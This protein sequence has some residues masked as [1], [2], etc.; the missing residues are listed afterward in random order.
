MEKFC[1]C[2]KPEKCPLAP[3]AVSGRTARVAL[4]PK[5]LQQSFHTLAFWLHLSEE[6]SKIKSIPAADL[7][8]LVLLLLKNF[9]CVNKQ[10]TK[11]AFLSHKGWKALDRLKIGEIFEKL[12]IPQGKNTEKNLTHC[13]PFC[14]TPLAR[15]AAAGWRLGSHLE[16]SGWGCGNSRISRSLENTGEVIHCSSGC[17]KLYGLDTFPQIPCTGNVFQCDS[18]GRQGLKAQGTTAAFTS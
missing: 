7:I 11:M 4:W 14:P 10:N 18:V 17:T 8:F 6:M 2:Q 3:V 1:F 16:A 12:N 9:P 15:S 5:P 13:V